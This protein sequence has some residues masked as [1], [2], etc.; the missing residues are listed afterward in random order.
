MTAFHTVSSSAEATLEEKLLAFADPRFRFEPTEHRYFFGR[1]ELTG[2]SAWLEQF[3]DSFNRE[4]RA[5]SCAAM[6]GRPAQEYL[7]EWNRAADI[8]TKTHAFIE[9]HYDY[10]RGLLSTPPDLFSKD[11]E[12]SLRCLK[13][14][15]LA[16]KRLANYEAVAQELRLF[17]TPPSWRG[18]PRRGRRWLRRKRKEEQGWCGTLDMLARH[19]PSGKLY[20]IDWKTSKKIGRE[21]DRQPWRLK[22][23]FSDLG[24]HEH[25][26]YSLQ[27]S[28]YRVL[29]EL[30]GIETSG[31]AIGWLPTGSTEPE[32]IPAIDYRSRVR[33]LLLPI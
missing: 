14:L 27:I 25:N 21:R 17:Y 28:F 6:S 1:R 15:S 20:V 32:L 13:F 9:R 19:K 30:A 7:A 33:P 2:A 16:G 18:T 31:G 8:G 26:L 12:V 29:L 4:E 22:G 5:A 24:K 10:Q 11:G 3:K 23:V